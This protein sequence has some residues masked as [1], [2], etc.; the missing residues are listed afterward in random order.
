MAPGDVSLAYFPFGDK[1]AT[2]LRPVLVLTGP[3]GPIPEFIAAYMTSII[4]AAL[5]ATDILI[6]PAQPVVG[7]R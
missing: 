5:L 6:D 1:A 4:P 3:L 7:E 2:K